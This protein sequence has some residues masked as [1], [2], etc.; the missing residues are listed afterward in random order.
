MRVQPPT[1][2]VRRLK[3]MHRPET[4]RRRISGGCKLTTYLGDAVLG[5][6]DG[7][8]TTFGIVAGSVGAGLRPEVALVL[9]LAN[10]ISDGFSMAVS[11]YQSIATV[12]G[13]TDRA[14][15]EEERHLEIVPEGEREELRQILMTKDIDG[16]VD[17]I[18]DLFTRSRKVV[19]EF[20]VA[21]EHGLQTKTSRPVLSATATFLA[22]VGMGVLPLLPFLV[23]S[24]GN[25]RVFITSAV[26]TGLAF[27]C[28]GAVRGVVLGRHPLHAGMET[29]VTGGAAAFLA[30]VVA[31]VARGFTAL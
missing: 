11:N 25:S 20:I 23:P 7:C 17:E 22:F 18:L 28:I 30:F 31:Y 10:L 14:L 4:I 6:I 15:Q 9:G 1:E 12:R 8:V 3:E 27:A 13:Q 2:E 24:F 19:S 29:L 26:V 16:H 5:A 21:H